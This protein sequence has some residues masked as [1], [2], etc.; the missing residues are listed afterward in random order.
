MAKA[1]GIDLGTSNS[2]VAVMEGGSPT[3]IVNA[4]GARTTPSVVAFKGEERLV[5]QIA[6]RQGAL[7]PENTI[8]SA[9]RFVGRRYS[10]VADERTLVPYQVESGPNDTVRFQVS[11]RKVAPEEIS[12]MVLEKLVKDASAY[13]GEGIN[14]IAAA[15]L[16]IKES[17]I[18]NNAAPPITQVLYTLVIAN[19]PI[20]S[21]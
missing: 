3:V 2:V 17:R 5:G 20:F 12:A 14:C 19:T 7:N 9:K 11:G 16:P 13:L 8:Y 21:P 18:A 6:R 15:S 4:E 1:L 10:E